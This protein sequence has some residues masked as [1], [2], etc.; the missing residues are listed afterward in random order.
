MEARK[1]EIATSLKQNQNKS[2]SNIVNNNNKNI[3]IQTNK[4]ILTFNNDGEKS[5]SNTTTIKK[6][7]D[8][9]KVTYGG[10][11]SSD[12]FIKSIYTLTI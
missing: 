12:I 2:N 3:G 1:L 6:T 7:N 4:K 9:T 5:S 10:K 11:R 8:T